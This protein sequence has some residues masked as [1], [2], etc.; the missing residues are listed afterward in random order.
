MPRKRK[1]ETEAKDKSS[2][3]KRGKTLGGRRA[4]RSG[5]G[6]GGEAAAGGIKS[7]KGSKAGKK[8]KV[9]KAGSGADRPMSEDQK[10]RAEATNSELELEAIPSAQ[11]AEGA[12]TVKIVSWNINSLK[13][14][15]RDGRLADYVASEDPDVLALQELKLASE[16]VANEEAFAATVAAAGLG[17]F[18][19]AVWV[20]SANK[21]QSGVALL[22]KIPWLNVTTKLEMGGHELESDG[23]FVAAEFDD[24]IV[25]ATYTPNAGPKLVRLGRRVDVWDAALGAYLEQLREA[26]PGKAVV[27]TGDLNV[28]PFAIDVANPEKKESQPGFS[29][30][31]RDSFQAICARAGLI[32]TYRKLRDT[33]ADDHPL[34]AV[35]DAQIYS[36]YSYRVRGARPRNIGWR[37]DHFVVS[38]HALPRVHASII[39][40][41]SVVGSD[42]LPIVLV[43]E[44][45]TAATS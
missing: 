1:A 11:Q 16:A 45:T 29:P 4:L 23:R 41:A 44:S 32:D 6:G 19:H 38:E 27:W 24:F 13:A 8:G 37:L 43:L 9:G 2:P 7:G 15:S 30:A 14:A 40:P 36:F 35:M 42:H 28:A 20:P 25:V 18:P 10:R 17:H 31:E 12:R 26:A 33:V 21:G 3:E 34:A 22:S 5:A 39:R